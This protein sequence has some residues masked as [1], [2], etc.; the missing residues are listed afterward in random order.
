MKKVIL[1]FTGVLLLLLS[2]SANAQ[3]ST[4]VDYF[5][6]QWNVLAEGV[7]GGNSQMIVSLERKEGILDGMI[8]IGEENAIKFSKIEEKETSV[9]LYF[10]SSHGNN[11]SLF[12]EKKDGNH[13]G[14]SIDTS[15]MGVFNITGERIVKK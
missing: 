6:G 2:V 10:T 3:T 11:I 5:I 12:L 1:F 9:K 4:G 15:V 7:P 14:G 13:L 8:K